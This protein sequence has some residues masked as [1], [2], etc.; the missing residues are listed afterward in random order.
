LNALVG[1]RLARV[2]TT[3]GKTRMLNVYEVRFTPPRGAGRPVYLLD[4]P[5]YGYARAS[6][7]DRLAFRQLVADAVHRPAVRAVAWLLDLRRDPSVEDRAM[8]ELLGESGARV[9]AALTKSDTVP[10]AARGRRE[11]ALRHILHLDED[12]VLVTSARTGEGIEDL[13]L[14]FAGLLSGPAKPREA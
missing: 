11:Q 10:R 4:L 5:G 14:A 2:S 3:P 7:V 8:L 12:Q 13:R 6:K 9:L 1:E